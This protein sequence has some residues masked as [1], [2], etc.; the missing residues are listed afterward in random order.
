MFKRDRIANDILQKVDDVIRLLRQLSPE[1]IQRIDGLI[2]ISGPGHFGRA[3]T[4]E[5]TVMYDGK[6][7]KIR[8]QW[9]Y[10]EKEDL[11]NVPADDWRRG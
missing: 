6:E 9:A 3:M 11:E 10:D 8:A 7:Y 4:K 1:D 2:D 5:D